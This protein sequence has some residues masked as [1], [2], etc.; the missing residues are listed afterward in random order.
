[1][2]VKYQCP[3]CERRFV[4]WGAQK[5]N[6]KCPTCPDEELVRLGGIEGQTLQP[7]RLKRRAAKIG[8]APAETELDFADMD[9]ME[10]EEVV[11]E[12]GITELEFGVDQVVVDEEVEPVGV[13]LP[14]DEEAPVVEEVD[15]AT[16]DA[17]TAD[18]GDELVFDDEAAIEL[19][20]TPEDF[21][22][23]A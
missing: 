11:D 8:K 12:G 16:A 5:L 14:L 15:L 10:E 9:M 4:E 13:E 1:M 20:E 19:G 23:E 7:P 21:E 6:F 22:E 2:P 17:P 3:K 18:L